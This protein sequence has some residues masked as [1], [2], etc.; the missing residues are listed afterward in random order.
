MDYE[1]PTVAELKANWVSDPGPVSFWRR[2]IVLT[3]V[4]ALVL[5]VS[6]YGWRQFRA[7]QAYGSVRVKPPVV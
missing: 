1:K 3:V 2:P 7:T 5:A 4:T 6:V